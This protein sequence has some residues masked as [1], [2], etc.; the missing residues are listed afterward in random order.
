MK[1]LIHILA[2]L[3]VLTSVAF[4]DP[5]FVNDPYEDEFAKMQKYFNSMLDKHMSAPAITNYNYPRTNIQDKEKQIIIE[6]DL[7]GVEKKDI[8]L[9]IDDHNVLNLEGKKEQKI[10][11][12]DKDGN[13]V[14]KE[15]FYG[16]FQ[17]AIQLPENAQS[18]KLETNYKDG[19]LTITI[20]KKPVKKPEVKV[21]PIN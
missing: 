6:F 3:S 14:R 4:A 1:R 15:I 17:K 10:E 8:K 19:I 2:F 21:I 9:S 5:I 7:A 12:K 20:P 16:S 18:E 11:E 13:Y